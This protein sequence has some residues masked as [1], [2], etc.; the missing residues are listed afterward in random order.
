MES[1]DQTPSPTSAERF[2]NERYKTAFTIATML[3]LVTLTMAILVLILAS[4]R[5]EDRETEFETTLTAIYSTLEQTSAASLALTATPDRVPAPVYGQYPVAPGTESPVFTDREPCTVQ[6]LSGRIRD[7]DGALTDA[8]SVQVWGDFADVQTVPTGALGGFESGAWE[9]ALDGMRSRRVF[10]QVMGA[11][12]TLSAPVEIIFAAND[13]AQ[14]HARIDFK[15]G[16]P[17]H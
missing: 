11:E 2:A 13:C 14:N 17:L 1:H 3:F 10:V 7:A 9:L 15:Q 16:G 5:E 12:R 8:F 6:V 4:A